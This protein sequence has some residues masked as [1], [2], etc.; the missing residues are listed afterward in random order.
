MKYSNVAITG[1]GMVTPLGETFGR[2][3]ECW[4]KGVSVARKTLPEFSGTSL[5][6]LTAGVPI[7]GDVRSRLGGGRMLKFMSE[8]GVYGLVAAREALETSGAKD[9]HTAERIGL[10]AATGLATVNI[11]EVRATV[12]NSIDEDGAFSCELFG[13]RGISATNPLLSFRIL[14]NMSACIISIAEG[15]KGPNYIFTPW[16]GQSGA[17]IFEACQAVSS[18]AVDCAV[19]G[20]SD[21]PSHPASY[22]YLKRRGLIDD[23]EFPS[24][25]ASYL[26]LER[27][28]PDVMPLAMLHELSLS[29]AGGAVRD[30]LSDRLGKMYAAAPPVMLGLM[31]AGVD[32]EGVM[33]GVDGQTLT[34]GMEAVR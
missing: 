23:A 32:I 1:V 7:I 29:F 33:C 12:E 16:E 10:F 3:V 22:L 21:N 17:A 2:T 5:E 30:P 28:G 26:V 11:E 27:A 31:A 4:S 25:G 15:I 18:G 34:V 13:R 6:W 9:R 8:A 19:V 20:A 14:A 24:S